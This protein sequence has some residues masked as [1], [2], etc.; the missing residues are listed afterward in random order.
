MGTDET[1][2]LHQESCY[3]KKSRESGNGSHEKQHVQNL[4]ASLLPPDNLEQ[5]MQEK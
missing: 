2:G 1:T 3:I 4:D 5:A